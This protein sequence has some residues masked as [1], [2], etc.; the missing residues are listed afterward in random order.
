MSTKI[1]VYIAWNGGTRVSQ[2]EETFGMLVKVQYL[3]NCEWPKLAFN[4]S[5]LNQLFLSFISVCH[6]HGNCSRLT[7]LFT[8]TQRNR[9]AEC[10]HQHSFQKQLFYG[11]SARSQMNS[12]RTII[13]KMWALKK[14]L[15]HI[16]FFVVISKNYKTGFLQTCWPFY[17]IKLKDQLLR[18]RRMNKI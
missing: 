3:H 8:E 14:N 7:F 4:Y 17:V 1:T 10:W 15:T 6:Y 18:L 16:A 11:Y 12:C 2:I 5:K 9:N 13:A